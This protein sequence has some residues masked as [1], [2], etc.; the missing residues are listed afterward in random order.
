MITQITVMLDFFMNR[1]NMSLQM[2]LLSKLTATLI[3]RIF[4]FF[5]Y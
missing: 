5:M 3:A 2:S 1:L 4:Y